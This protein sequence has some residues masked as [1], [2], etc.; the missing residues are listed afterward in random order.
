LWRGE[1][2][3]GA[4]WIDGRKSEELEW[5]KGIEGNSRA[6]GT[7]NGNEQR[8]RAEKAENRRSIISEL[9]R[10]ITDRGNAFLLL[11]FFFFNFLS[12]LIMVHT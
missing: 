10:H 5:R 8:E 1:E 7:S 6:T 9:G 3:R 11:S 4:G 2:I 12:D